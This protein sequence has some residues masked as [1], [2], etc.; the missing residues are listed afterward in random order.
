MRVTLCLFIITLSLQS[1][2]FVATDVSGSLENRD[3]IV[4]KDNVEDS[5]PPPQQPQPQH[6]KAEDFA[7]TA[8]RLVEADDSSSLPVSL[9]PQHF[10]DRSLLDMFG[11]ASKEY[12]TER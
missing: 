12:L 10:D 2:Y 5:S 8:R 9:P 3:G 7:A 4:N 6:P 11:E 1:Q